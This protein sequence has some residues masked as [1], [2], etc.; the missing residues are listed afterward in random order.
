VPEHVHL[1][2]APRDSLTTI[3][4]FQGFIKEKVAREAIQWLEQNSPDWLSHITVREGSR[5]RRRF[6]QPGGG[7]DRSIESAETL[8][9]MI[10]YI[11]LN[12]IR[13]KLV[14]RTIDRPWSSARWYAG[15]RPALIEIDPTIPTS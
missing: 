2:V 6:W 11:H 1:I 8:E 12:P 3:G 5:T 10:E 9:R 7:N 13:C 15:T 14:E 4:Q